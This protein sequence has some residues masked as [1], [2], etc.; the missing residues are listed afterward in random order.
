MEDIMV[1][2]IYLIPVLSLFAACNSDRMQT[3]DK[4]SSMVFERDGGGNLVFT[5]S[6]GDDSNSLS[7]KVTRRNFRDT[8]ITMTLSKEP[9]N[10]SLFE[11]FFQALEGRR[12]VVGG[13]KESTLPTGTWAHIYLVREKE[14]MEVTNTELRNSLLFFETMVRIRL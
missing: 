10:A 13:F 3:V 14:R 12:Q 8:T 6:P 5:A 11:D 9:E 4:Y 2:F 1:R 7:I